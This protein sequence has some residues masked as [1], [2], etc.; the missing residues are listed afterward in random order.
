MDDPGRDPRL[1]SRGPPPRERRERADGGPG[2]GRRPRRRCLDDLRPLV[3]RGHYRIGRHAARH[4]AT[5]G[6]TEPDIVATVL[7]GRELM[8]YVRDE[9]LLVLGWLPVSR[10]VRLPLHV[11]LEFSRPRWVDVVTAFIPDD[12]HRVASRR[13]LAEALRWDAHE[14]RRELVGEDGA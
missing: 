9:R 13:R 5:E 10:E 14:P 7:H 6:F 3:R 2:T 12:P 11:V 4:A 1:E 8:R